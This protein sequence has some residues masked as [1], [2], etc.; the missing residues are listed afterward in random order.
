LKQRRGSEAQLFNQAR[1]GRIA[2]AQGRVEKSQSL[3]ARVRVVVIERCDQVA[4][5]RVEKSGECPGIVAHAHHVDPA[6]IDPAGASRVA[7]LCAR[8]IP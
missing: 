8:E 3:A 7:S 4:P 1:V 2:Q 5:L 6:L